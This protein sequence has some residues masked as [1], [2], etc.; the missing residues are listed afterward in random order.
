MKIKNMY[1]QG[2]LQLMQ[3]MKISNVKDSRLR[4][5]FIRQVAEY[6][7][8]TYEKER[9][10]TI[11]GFAQKDINGKLKSDENGLVIFK[12]GGEQGCLNELEIL[13][14]DFLIIDMN[15]QNKEMLLTVS[16]LVF[17]DT[18]IPPLSGVVSVAHDML[19]DEAEKVE[20]FYNLQDVK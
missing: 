1:L 5:R 12:E 10:E 9:L 7:V 14:N 19:C 13:D 17:D 16:R 8:S 4:N 3:D 15:E 2:V 20:E 6:G 18:V 11:E